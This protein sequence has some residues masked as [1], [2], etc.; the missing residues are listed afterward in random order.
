[1][2]EQ[3]LAFV[4]P[5]YAGFDPKAFNEGA[6]THEIFDA[7]KVLGFSKTEARKVELTEEKLA[8]MYP[9]LNPSLMGATI[10]HLAGRTIFLL[11]FTGENANLQMARIVGLSYDP[12]LCAPG[13]IRHTWWET[14]KT[15]HTNPNIGQ[16]G[17][18]LGD[19]NY[20]FF[21]FVHCS[22]NPNE[23]ELQYRVLTGEKFALPA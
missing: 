13:S 7:A 6:I 10:T 20:Y 17:L 14:T 11:V 3:T 18:N 22:R 12:R 21:N 23:F 5:M 16:T 19:G 4:K 9:H 2:S 8:G 15:K 1:M